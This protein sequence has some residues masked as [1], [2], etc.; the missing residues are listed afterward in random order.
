VKGPGFSPRILSGA[1]I[2]SFPLGALHAFSVLVDP[3]QQTTG[4]SRATISAVYSLAIGALALGVLLGPRVMTRLGPGKVAVLSGTVGG[5][6]LALAGFGGTIAFLFLGYG[7][8]F[9][10]ANGLGY[11]LFLDRAA[12]AAP[13]SRGI[14]IGVV[15]SVYGIGAMSFSGLIG[16]LVAEYSLAAAFEALI[17]ATLLGAGYAGFA[18]AGSSPVPASRPASASSL[19]PVRATPVRVTG[20]YWLVYFCGATGGLMAIAHAAPIL[21]Q[22]GSSQATAVLAPMVLAIGNC[23]GSL[24]GGRLGD[25]AS[26]RWGLGSVLFLSGLAL[27]LASATPPVGFLLLALTAAGLCYGAL[28]ALVPALLRQ[29]LGDAEGARLFAWV[30]T[31]WG[32]AGILGPGLAGWFFDLAGNYRLALSV[33][34]GLAFFGLTMAMFLPG[35]AR[36]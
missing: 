31:A 33:A 23:L 8:M 20:I 32:A 5:L 25:L 22:A 3:L 1:I 36:R 18:F 35:A 28:I 9:G 15:T 2:L 30:F 7:L 17:L 21:A 11:G 19:T 24:G 13:A 27:I 26:P 34:A 29:A 6:G 4:G 12:V 14:A 10:F 16:Y